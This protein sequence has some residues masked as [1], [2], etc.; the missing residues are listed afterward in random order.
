[1][2]QKE[3][4]TQQRLKLKGYCMKCKESKSQKE[5]LTQQRLKPL[6][7]SSDGF[8]HAESERSSNTTKIETVVPVKIDHAC[9][10][11]ERS[12]NTTKIETQGSNGCNNAGIGQKEVLTQQRLKQLAIQLIDTPYSVRKKF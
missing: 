5:V 3:V 4:L 1:M 7:V 9:G 12:S 6:S 8:V 11:S 2:S 10:M